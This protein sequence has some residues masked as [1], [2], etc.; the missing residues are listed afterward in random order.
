MWH[1]I[2]DATF[3]IWE[4][5]E[6]GNGR[7]FSLN[8]ETSSLPNC[9]QNKRISFQVYHENKEKNIVARIDK[10]K[11]DLFIIKVYLPNVFD[12]FGIN[13]KI[14]NNKAKV[15]KNSFI[16][17]ARLVRCISHEV[18]HAFDPLFSN[19]YYTDYYMKRYNSFSG[20]KVKEFYY[21]S[22]I[23]RRAY[24]AEIE[25]K[26]RF[27]SEQK[28]GKKKAMS[29]CFDKELNSGFDVYLMKKDKNEWDKMKLKTLKIIDHYYSK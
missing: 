5:V 25:S 14:K 1:L 18:T 15:L 12:I 19:T 10:R 29:L 28:I 2:K 13:R 6:K 22:L 20:E 3:R 27:F 24:I 4:K 11:K 9:R 8:Y 16:N 17:K 7:N 23:E 26:I 21:N